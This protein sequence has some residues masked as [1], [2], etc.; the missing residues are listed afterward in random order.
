MIWLNVRSRSMKARESPMWAMASLVPVRS[1]TIVVDP[2]PARSEFS[3]MALVS[4]AL[5]ERSVLEQ[6]DGLV[7]ADVL[8]VERGQL[9]HDHRARHVTCG[10]TAHAIC[11]DEQVRAGVSGVLVAG[12]GAETQV[13]ARGIAQCDGHGSVPELE[14]GLADAQGRADLDR[15]RRR[16]LVPP[17]EGAVGR[18]KV[19]DEP[20]LRPE[21][22]W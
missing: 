17:D 8:V 2:M 19:L 21:A 10:V 1:M 5:A 16:E 4:L 9:S 3:R 15:L 6:R 12:L 14:D 18:A 7:G 13:G 22:S 11:E 20:T